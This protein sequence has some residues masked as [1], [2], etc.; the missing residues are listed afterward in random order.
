MSNKGNYEI[1]LDF[2]ED[3]KQNWFQ[4]LFKINPYKRK[5]HYTLGSFLWSMY[6]TRME[7]N[8]LY[9]Y[10]AR[11]WQKLGCDAMIRTPRGKTRSAYNLNSEHMHHL[12]WWVLEQYFEGN[13]I[14]GPKDE[15]QP[16]Q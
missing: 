12:V 10:E 11:L 14:E 16:K 9:Q 5:S 3:K 2:M 6:W 4:R 8:S 7:D 1:K 13:L 15:P